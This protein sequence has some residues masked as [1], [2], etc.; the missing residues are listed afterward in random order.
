MCKD[1]NDLCSASES[2]NQ[3]LRDRTLDLPLSFCLKHMTSLNSLPLPAP[4]ESLYY[5]FRGNFYGRVC[6]ELLV[7]R[8]SLVCIR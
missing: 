8:I 4:S 5:W 2:R 6:F 3:S 1:C 7:E